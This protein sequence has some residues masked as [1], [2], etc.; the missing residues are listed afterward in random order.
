M[1]ETFG[2]QLNVPADFSSLA[3]FFC[4]TEMFTRLNLIMYGPENKKTAC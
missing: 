3:H 2:L 4:K 1:E